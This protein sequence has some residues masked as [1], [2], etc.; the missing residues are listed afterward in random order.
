MG[1][2]SHVLKTAVK[3]IVKKHVIQFIGEQLNKMIV[4]QI[5]INCV[6]MGLL[7]IAILVNG[8]SLFGQASLFVSSGIIIL[9]LFH[10]TLFTIP[11]IIR[12]LLTMTRYKMFPLIPMIFGGVRP[13]EIVAY[14]IGSYGWLARK[15]KKEY[16][17]T[18]GD[19]LPNANQLVDELWIHVGLRFLVFAVSIGIYIILFNFV[20]R[21]LLLLPAFGDIGLWVYAFPF[22][23]AIDFLFNTGIT[24]W[25]MDKA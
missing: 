14:W 19:W 11:K 13:S 7:L 23:M 15:I 18:I 24:Q 17:K 20:A 12:A 21:P 8:F 1:F 2:W 16:D 4:M 10:A 25:I 22:S 6:K 9:L 5:I 3:H